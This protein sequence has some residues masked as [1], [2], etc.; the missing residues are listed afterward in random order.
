MASISRSYQSLMVCRGTGWHS[1]GG[2]VGARQSSTMGAARRGSWSWLSQSLGS[3]SATEGGEL[4]QRCPGSQHS[5]VPVTAPTHSTAW[6]PPQHPP[7]HLGVPGQQGARHDHAQQAL[8]AVVKGPLKVARRRGAAQHAPDERDPGDLQEAGCGRA[9]R[10]LVGLVG[11]AVP[12]GC[13]VRAPGRR[14]LVGVRP[15]R[16]APYSSA[17]STPGRGCGGASAPPAASPT[18]FMSWM[19]IFQI[20]VSTSAPFMPSSCRAHTAG[21]NNVGNRSQAACCRSTRECRGGR[22]QEAFPSPH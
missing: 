17:S 4:A 16:R 1:D 15:L 21:G 11:W 7:T 20:S 6:T 8:H 18:G 19:R 5:P 13:S 2:S 9:G 12:E 10:G 3:A 22:A 14:C